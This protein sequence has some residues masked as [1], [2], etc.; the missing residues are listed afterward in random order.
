M[1][2]QLIQELNTCKVQRAYHMVTKK[3][4][5]KANKY[6]VEILDTKILPSN[7]NLTVKEYYTQYL[8]NDNN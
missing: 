2:A 6:L 3:V 4:V 5:A 7:K 8:K 1:K